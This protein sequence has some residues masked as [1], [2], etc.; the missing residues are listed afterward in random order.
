MLYQ[1][2]NEWSFKIYRLNCFNVI[3]LPKY[4]K[5]RPGLKMYLSDLI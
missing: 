4:L 1:M 3:F 2:Y 5:Q